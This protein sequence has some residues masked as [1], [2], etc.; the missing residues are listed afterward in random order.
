VYIQLCSVDVQPFVNRAL[1]WF[2]REYD[3]DKFRDVVRFLYT[4]C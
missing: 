2:V 1:E 3:L 4:S